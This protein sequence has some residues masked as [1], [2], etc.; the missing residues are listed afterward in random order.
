M[1]KEAISD[2]IGD[3][4]KKNGIKQLVI[5]VSGEIDSAVTSTLAA[6][7]GLPTIVVSMP[8]HQNEN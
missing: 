1:N 4:A 3:Y 2:W 6:E 5:G 8:I 7:T